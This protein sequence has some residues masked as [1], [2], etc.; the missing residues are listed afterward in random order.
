[1]K[2]RGGGEQHRSASL[3]SFTTRRRSAEFRLP[4]RKASTDSPL[5][6]SPFPHLRTKQEDEKSAKHGAWVASEA[7]QC[8]LVMSHW[9]CAPPTSP[10][11]TRHTCS[12]EG[13]GGRGRRARGAA[14]PERDAGRSPPQAQESVSCAEAKLLGAEDRSHRNAVHRIQERSLAAIRKC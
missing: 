11:R 6:F 14:D 12:E 5:C 7:E 9:G 3:D 1:M 4:L 2:I 8:L 13:S 10:P